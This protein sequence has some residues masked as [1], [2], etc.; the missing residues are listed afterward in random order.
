MPTGLDRMKN[1]L[2]SAEPL[3]MVEQFVSISLFEFRRS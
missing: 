1:E 2:F 3:T